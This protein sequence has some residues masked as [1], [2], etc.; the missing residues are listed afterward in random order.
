MAQDGLNSTGLKELA[1]KQSSS[2][3]FGKEVFWC[4]VVVV[5]RFF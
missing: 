4:F 1:L 3:P 5:L 2:V